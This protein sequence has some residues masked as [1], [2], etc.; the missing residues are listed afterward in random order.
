LNK[1]KL[2]DIRN[3]DIDNG[4]EYLP[5]SLKEFYCSADQRKGAKCKTISNLFSNEQGI[6]EMEYGS[7]KNF[8]QKLQACKQKLYVKPQIEKELVSNGLTSK[9]LTQQLISDKHITNPEHT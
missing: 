3:T 4:L 1:L 5:D 2:L 9:Q 8:P 6:I 7:I